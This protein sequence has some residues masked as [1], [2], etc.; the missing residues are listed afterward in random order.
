[1]AN[2]DIRELAKKNNVY[3]W[4]IAHEYGI[5][6]NNFSR[7]LRYELSDNEKARITEIIHKIHS[8]KMEEE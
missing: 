6:D 3:L 1:M 8:M 7:K 5:N 4:E 2:N